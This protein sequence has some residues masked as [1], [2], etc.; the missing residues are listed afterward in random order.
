M[1]PLRAGFSL[2]EVVANANN[3]VPIYWMLLCIAYAVQY[4]ERYR[5]GRVRAAQLEIQLVQPQL[6]A[7][8]I[9]L[10][11]HFLVNAMSAVSELM[12]QD[13]K[14][15]RRMLAQLSQFLRLVLESSDEQEVTLEKELHL[16]RLYLEIEQTRFPDRLAVQYHIA[17]ETLGALLPALLLQPVV[18]N[19]VRPGIAPKAGAGE[20][21]VSTERQADQLILRVKNNG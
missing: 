5:E 18:E 3:W 10:Q 20:L 13:V 15:A 11:P 8:E 19:A 17:S 7:L 14:A 2:A 9:Q 1:G 4:Q 6:Q 12:S 16:A 21:A